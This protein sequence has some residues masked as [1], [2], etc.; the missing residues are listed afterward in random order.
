MLSID[1]L[2]KKAENRYILTTLVAKRSKQINQ[3]AKPLIE[4]QHSLKPLFLALEEVAQDK[5]KWTKE[6]Q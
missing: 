1:E 2:I 5:L 3:G 6:N 4:V